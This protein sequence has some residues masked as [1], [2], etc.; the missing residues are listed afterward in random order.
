[1]AEQRT[2]NVSARPSSEELDRLVAG[3]HHDPHHVLGRHDGTVRA[4]RPGSFRMAV[5]GEGGNRVEMRRVHDAGGDEAVVGDLGERYDLEVEYADGMVFHYADPYRFWPTVG[6]VNL[7]LLGEGRHRRLW[8]TLG[9]HAREH[10]GEKGTSFAVWAPSARAVRVVGDFNLWDGRLHPMRA[11]G[12]SGV[13][14]LFVP[15][16]GPGERYKYEI[17]SQAGH[18]TLKADPVAFRAEHPPATASVVSGSSHPWQDGDWMR[19][20]DAADRYAAPMSIYELHPGSWR[21]HVEGDTP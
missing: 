20:R 7:H 16:V 15:G 5:V 11:L 3:E 17:L 10:Q 21:R 4:Y 6:D 19:T 2:T 1:M 8:K 13:W 18:L 14:E 12:A 9:A